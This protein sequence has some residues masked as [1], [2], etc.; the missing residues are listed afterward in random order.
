MWY[1]NAVLIMIFNYNFL[2]INFKY[3]KE[4]NYEHYGDM[5]KFN[6]F[7]FHIW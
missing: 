2:G 1:G 7:K 4:S 6:T 5:F 3:A